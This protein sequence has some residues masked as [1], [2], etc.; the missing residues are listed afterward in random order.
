MRNVLDTKFKK[1]ITLLILVILILTVIGVENTSV[2]N[3]KDTIPSE[4]TRNGVG[5]HLV[6]VKDV[7]L[8]VDVVDTPVLREQGL[9]GRG[10]LQALEGML[11]VF[12]EAG[13]YHFWM[14]EMNFPIDIIWIGDDFRVVDIT[15]SA[16][17]DSFPQTF[18]PKVPARYVLEVNAGFS[19]EY[20]VSIGDII[21]LTL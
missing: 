15:H 19:R 18:A 17:E 16:S 13:I 20:G 2:F 1:T 12:D 21:E 14:K 8:K 11:F 5:K 6:R 10:S 4:E 7:L 3:K 9:S